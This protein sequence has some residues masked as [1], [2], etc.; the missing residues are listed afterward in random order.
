MPTIRAD[1]LEAGRVRGRTVGTMCRGSPAVEVTVSEHIVSI[2][3]GIIAH[4]I[5]VGGIR[6]A[7]RNDLAVRIA[8]GA[9]VLLHPALFAK[10]HR[11]IDVAVD[12]GDRGVAGTRLCVALRHHGDGIRRGEGHHIAIDGAATVGGVGSH[13]ILRV[14]CQ[15]GKRAR[16]HARACAVNR[17]AVGYGWEL[18]G[19]APADTAGS[20][21]RV[22]VEE[23]L[24]AA[25]GRDIADLR[26][27]TGAHREHRRSFSGIANYQM[28]NHR[29]RW[30]SGRIVVPPQEDQLGLSSWC[31]ILHVHP[32]VNG[33]TLRKVYYV[34]ITAVIC[35]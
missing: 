4:G 31:R 8:R 2:V 30:V 19:V 28:G 35:L 7:V 16:E 26:H 9:E 21:R 12:V 3:V 32:D 27:R 11:V 22:I 25:Y 34:R 18:R 1:A 33:V 5:R 15:P 10:F 6:T 20:Y 13:V 14:G 24:A 23:H 29:T 17:V